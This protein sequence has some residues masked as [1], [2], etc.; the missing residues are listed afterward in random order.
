MSL[1]S[2]NSDMVVSASWSGA[3]HR[4]R[5]MKQSLAKKTA[6][7]AQ[8]IDFA[9]H[10]AGPDA[11]DCACARLV[12]AGA[13]N[14]AR[15]QIGDRQLLSTLIEDSLMREVVIMQA[16]DFL[17]HEVERDR[18]CRLETV[19]DLAEFLKNG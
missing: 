9:M 8:I 10:K 17:G 18:F 14:I 3:P 5:V 19:T 16:E 12:L 7:S 4:E 1:P 6:T 15:S 11:L 13:L 2:V